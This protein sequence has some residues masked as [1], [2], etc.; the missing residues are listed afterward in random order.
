[1]YNIMSI[2]AALQL[3][4][5]EIECNVC[6]RRHV[7]AYGRSPGVCDCVSARFDAGVRAIHQ[8]IDLSQLHRA[9]DV[10]LRSYAQAW[11]LCD[12]S[13]AELHISLDQAMRT[14]R[15]VRNF[16]ALTL[17]GVSLRELSLRELD[18]Q[19]PLGLGEGLPI[20]W[21]LALP[22]QSVDRIVALMV[23]HQ[24][25]N[26]S[27]WAFCSHAVDVAHVA[28]SK[29]PEVPFLMRW[30]SRSARQKA[31]LLQA[32]AACS[33]LLDARQQCMSQIEEL[34]AVESLAFPYLLADALVGE[35]WLQTVRM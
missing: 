1:M 27:C 30:L 14:S 24:M 25:L 22:Q 15:E 23:L 2:Q 35:L 4:N 32:V 12:V 20:H 16:A 28:A 19:V 13:P 3:G 29:L 18:E 21:T 9:A 17:S 31:A 26:A 6:G 11:R 10:C 7:I 8:V 33:R 5:V 34:C